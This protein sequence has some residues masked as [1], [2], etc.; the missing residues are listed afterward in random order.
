MEA[1]SSDNNAT[2]PVKKT[3]VILAKL[4]RKAI[5][6]KVVAGIAGAIV[7]F[8]LS[9][10][11]A[12]IAGVPS[13]VMIVASIYAAFFNAIFATS[14][15][16]VGGPN[17]AVAL[18]TGAAVAPF[19]P[20]EGDL[21]L[22]YVFALCLLV[23]LIQ[24]IISMVLRKVDIM[25]YVSTTVID[26]L[27]M[28][29]GAIFILTSLNWAVGL[30]PDINAQWIVFDA[31][32]SLV[33]L[34][35]GLANGYAIMVSGITILTGL[36]CWQFKSVKNFAILFA[37]TAGY[38]LSSFLD[39]NYHTRIDQVGWLTLN[40]FE[41]S[42]PD[43]RPVSWQVTMELIGPALAI[44]IIGI[45]QTLSIAKALRD[46][47]EKY[48]PSQ[49]AFSQGFQH[50]FM[51]FFH[52]A[53]VSNS[54]NKSSLQRSLNGNK[55]SFIVAAI[56]TL[57]FVTWFGA[58]VAAIPMPALAGCMML[59]GM[60][61]LN[62]WKHREYF[63]SGVTI[64]LVFAV[65]AVSAIALSIMAAIFIGA[66]LSIILHLLKFATPEA[67][68][69]KIGNEL[70]IKISGS[71]FYVSGA[72]INKIIENKLDMLALDTIKRVNIDLT[73]AMILTRDQIDNDWLH[74]LIRE[75]IPITVNASTSQ[76]KQISIL[77]K[78]GAIP[79]SCE[80]FYPNSD[81]DDLNTLIK[82]SKINRRMITAT[83]D[84]MVKSNI[85]ERRK[86]ERRI[87]NSEL[88]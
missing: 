81:M 70:S 87:P 59:V 83:A 18:I 34:T 11:F 54:F 10:G 49:E 73:E 67:N 5:V 35:E 8:P 78:R 64:L 9:I 33:N 69:V 44:A 66:L 3:K 65:S 52:G 6:D 77:Q 51:G 84:E 72:K 15:Y 80:V 40:L 32:T 48:N 17:T 7:A 42:L 71:Y 62:P 14:K 61:M 45:L 50:I 39:A 23:G 22:G 43:L 38:L 75:E 12:L 74:R 63:K 2:G 60:S 36:I 25:D 13:E 27:T 1:L 29:I 19:A 4:P 68:I 41:T 37:I 16:G 82:S 58:I 47:G 31:F 30:A 21:Y 53:P 56:F 28:G 46:K 20:R 86:Q 85:P 79:E 55:W 88:A 76:K 24:M 26:G 57:L